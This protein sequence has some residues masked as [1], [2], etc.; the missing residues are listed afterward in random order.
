MVAKYGKMEAQ[1]FLL[2][3]GEGLYW[4][5]VACAHST[6]VLCLVKV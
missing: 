6:G 5:C 4:L 3:S 1:C 2:I